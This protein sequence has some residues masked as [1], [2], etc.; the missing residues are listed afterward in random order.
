MKIFKIRS[1][2]PLEDR[3]FFSL[4]E[5]IEEEDRKQILRYQ[6]WQ[7][8]QRSLLGHLLSRYAI[9]QE[10]A[11]TNKEIQIR[12]HAY[13]KPYIKD[14]SQIHY[15]I[16]HSGEWVV[17]AIGKSP[18]GID[19][20]N[21]REDWDLIGEQVFSESEKYWSQNSYKRKAILWTIK[22]AYVKYLGIGLSKS[23]N[24]F[25][26]D[27]K[28]KIIT[29]VQKP[30]QTSFDYFVLDNDYVCSECGYTKGA[31]YSRKVCQAELD[32]FITSVL[33]ISY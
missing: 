12:R 23:L 19:V 13:G 7:D 5:L 25:S 24:S 9:I 27:I 21:R 31:Y 16:S 6:F 4:L 28:R 29:E 18:I 8:R 32:T 20:E 14:Y 11:L 17:V 15:N 26:I 22:E 2:K 1:Q 10:Y 33:D 3:M 30:F